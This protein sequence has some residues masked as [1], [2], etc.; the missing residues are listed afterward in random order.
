[1]TRSASRPISSASHERKTSNRLIALRSP[2]AGT[3]V[4]RR[5]GL[6]SSST[7][8]SD[9][10]LRNFDRHARDPAAP[11]SSRTL[12]RRTSLSVLR[13][14]VAAT[15]W[16]R[17]GFE[18]TDLIGEARDYLGG[19]LTGLVVAEAGAPA[20]DRIQS[21]PEPQ[22]EQRHGERRRWPSRARRIAS[23]IEDAI[24]L[25]EIAS[26]CGEVLDERNAA[27]NLKRAVPPSSQAIEQPLRFLRSTDRT[28]PR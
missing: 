24:F 13:T 19:E 9:S 10:V 17:S 7:P 23:S 6:A 8:R 25:V 27:S 26:R 15:R 16:T 22:E 3:R 12:K 11:R 18:T 4:R 14:R 2:L 1:M 20:E 5:G 21:G 28:R